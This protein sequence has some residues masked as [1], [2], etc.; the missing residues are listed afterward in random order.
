MTCIS[1]KYNDLIN[2]YGRPHRE[3]SE[4]I[5]RQ[6]ELSFSPGGLGILSITDLPAAVES[7]RTQ[8]CEQACTLP[9][10]DELYGTHGLG[11]DTV[12]GG[13]VL[14]ATLA[15]KWESGSPPGSSTSAGGNAC[16]TSTLHD[17]VHSLGVVWATVCEAVAQVCDTWLGFEEG[18]GL[19]QALRGAGE[20]KARLVGYG[21]SAAPPTSPLWQEWHKDYGLFTAIS[22]PSYFTCTLPSGDEGV[23]TFTSLPS[24]PTGVGLHVMRPGT[25]DMVHIPLSPGSLGVQVGEAAQ[26]L[27]RGRL[28]AVPHCVKREG[29]EG[30]GLHRSTFVV[31]CQPPYTAPLLPLSRGGGIEARS[32]IS[33]DDAR[34]VLAAED[35]VWGDTLKGVLPPL[36]NRWP[37]AVKG[38]V[39]DFN[40]FGKATVK[41]Y[42]GKGGAQRK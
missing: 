31:F 40:S 42:F 25:G 5:L 18:G 12:E 29:G 6:V 13:C 10:R 36:A 19:A 30:E 23:K 37:G 16:A 7:L 34:A 21:S 38:K 32:A 17:S 2:G 33:D 14:S 15:V 9:A 1:L 27:S 11:S 41:Q 22:A 26:I 28:A 39:C 4:E 8:V 35:P 3:F 20:A 24:P